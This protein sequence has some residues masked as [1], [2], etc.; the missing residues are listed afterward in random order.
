MES[1]DDKLR[2][3]EQWCRDTQNFLNNLNY[4]KFRETYDADTSYSDCDGGEEV[5]DENP[6]DK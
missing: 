4:E 3:I 1:H 5:C 2:D 6:R